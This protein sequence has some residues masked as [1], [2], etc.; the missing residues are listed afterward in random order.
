MSASFS[1][2]VCWVRPDLNVVTPLDLDARGGELLSVALH[3]HHDPFRGRVHPVWTNGRDRLL[4]GCVHV[5][6]LHTC[7]CV[8]G[9]GK[10]C[11][12]LFILKK[13]LC[14]FSRNCFFSFFL[15]NHEGGLFINVTIPRVLPMKPINFRRSIKLDIFLIYKLPC[16]YRCFPNS[17]HGAVRR[18]CSLQRTD[19]QPLFTYTPSL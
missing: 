12:S 17:F 9:M 16:T 19:T 4:E 14:F 1:A 18:L 10:Y 15:P 13:K 11:C 5:Q 6:Q 7:V 8:P 3:Q 2:V